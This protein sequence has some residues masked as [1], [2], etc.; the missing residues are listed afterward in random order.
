MTVD[1]HRGEALR[2]TLPVLKIAGGLIVA[3]TAWR[4]L[5]RNPEAVVARAARAAGMPAIIVLSSD[6]EVKRLNARHRGRNKPTNVLTF[7][8][9]ARGQPGEIVLALGTIRREAREGVA[10]VIIEHNISFIKQVAHEV[11]VMDR[12]RRVAY[13]SP[14]DVTNRKEVV[15]VY[16]GTAASEAGAALTIA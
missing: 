5:L 3:N 2:R 14:E 9:V 7:D 10:V 15:D 12:G 6:T 16:L 1:C 11:L 13:G 4:R 8:P